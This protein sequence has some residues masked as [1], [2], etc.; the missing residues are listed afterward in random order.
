MAETAAANEVRA[1]QQAG[2][3]AMIALDALSPTPGGSTLA[4][5]REAAQSEP[6]GVQAVVEGMKPGG[7]FADLRTAFNAALAQDRGF[8]SAYDGA[9]A[10]ITAYGQARLLASRLLSSAVSSAIVSASNVTTAPP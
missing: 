4:R 9:A 8:A 2:E 3:R 5:V 6:G 10:D 1:V 7:K